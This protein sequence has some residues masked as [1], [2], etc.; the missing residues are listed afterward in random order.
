MS[1]VKLQVLTNSAIQCFKRCRKLYWFQ[2]IKLLRTAEDA[3]VLRFGTAM[4]KAIEWLENVNLSAALVYVRQTEWSEARRYTPY[5][6]AALIRGYAGQ[7]EHCQHI[8]ETIESERVFEIPIINP[9]TGRPS[10]TFQASGKIDGVV[11]LHDSRSANRETKT[12]GNDITSDRYWRRL[13]IDPQISMYWL[14]SPSIKTTIYDVIKRPSINPKKAT[15]EDK[16]KYKKDGAL[17]ANQRTTDEDPEAWEVRLLNDIHQRPEFYFVRRPIPRL[18]KDL[19]EFRYELWDV[20]KDI[21]LACLTGRFYRTVSYSTC[22]SCPFF[23]LCT[24]LTAWDGESVPEGF[25]RLTTPNPELEDDN[26]TE[27]TTDNHRTSS[28]GC[29]AAVNATSTIG[30]IEGGA[31][32]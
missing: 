8:A 13:L 27:Q 3:Y 25:Q 21:H 31:P 16:R 5:T 20:A 6:L 24:G 26:A 10:R 32:T 15:P 1:D 4:H 28:A 2:Y 9:E 18:E 12:T 17:Y 30:F 7:Y 19:H 11:K 29:D 23:D 14:A 22:D